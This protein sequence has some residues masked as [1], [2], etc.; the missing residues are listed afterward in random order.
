MQEVFRGSG[1]VGGPVWCRSRPLLCFTTRAKLPTGFPIKDVAGCPWAASWGTPEQDSPKLPSP[2]HVGPTTAEQVVIMPAMTKHLPCNLR[3]EGEPL[4]VVYKN[5]MCAHATSS[6]QKEK[7]LYVNAVPR[8]IAHKFPS[9]VKPATAQLHHSCSPTRAWK[10]EVPCR[11]KNARHTGM[12]PLRKSAERS[13]KASKIILSSGRI[14]SALERDCVLSIFFF[15][16]TCQTNM[17]QGHSHTKL[18]NQYVP[19]CNL[20]RRELHCTPTSQL[21]QNKR[22][23]LHESIGNL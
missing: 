7:Q 17:C 11:E 23:F 2:L 12:W 8:K 14:P 20:S 22:S 15:L 10:E 4:Q 3:V 16:F 13:S 19:R 5:A 21:K 18:F 1:E 9:R 6:E